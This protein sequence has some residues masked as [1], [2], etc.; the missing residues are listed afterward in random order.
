MR[1]KGIKPV[2]SIDTEKHEFVKDEKGKYFHAECYG[3]YLLEKKKMNVEEV[4]RKVA[5]RLLITKKEIRE[6]EEKDKF[7]RWIMD[8]YDGTL[9]SYFFKE[10]KSCS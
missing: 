9:P 7:L 1:E 8:Y 6:Q 3:Y 4:D 10:I 5:E 2:K